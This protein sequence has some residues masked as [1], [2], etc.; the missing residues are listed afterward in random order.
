M[1]LYLEHY[2]RQCI[3]TVKPEQTQINSEGEIQTPVLGCLLQH[4]PIVLEKN[5]LFR[6]LQR[7]VVRKGKGPLA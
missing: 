4:E 2:S 7:N 1:R 3:F 6:I 5:S